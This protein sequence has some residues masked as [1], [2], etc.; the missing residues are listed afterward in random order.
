MFS[1]VKS[2]W[3]R[4][5][6]L[7]R[8]LRIAGYLLSG[9]LV[10]AALLGLALPALLGAMLPGKLSDL[11]GRPVS[12]TQLS[13]NPFTLELEARE[14]ALAESDGS[15]FTGFERLGLN[16]SLWQSIFNGAPTLANL[17]LDGPFGHLLQRADGSF[18]FSSLLPTNDAPPTDTAPA[19]MPA[20]VIDRLR[21]GR[22]Q[23]SVTDQLH[24][25]DLHYPDINF[26][27][28]ALDSRAALADIEHNRFELH[29]A[30]D[31]QGQFSL[32]GHFDLN[33]PGAEVEFQLANQSLLKFWPALEGKL[34]LEPQSARLSLGGKLT[35]ALGT[36]AKPEVEFSKG[37]MVLSDVALKPADGE[38]LSLAS[39]ALDGI[40]M[41]LTR[42]QATAE[43]LAIDGLKLATAFDKQGLG[44]QR[45]WQSQ[46][47]ET[48]EQVGDT[49]AAA[50]TEAQAPQS[51]IEPDAN[52]AWTARLDRFELGNSEL[53]VHEST[54]SDKVVDW[55]I[56]DIQLETGALGSDLTQA[57]TLA[58]SLNLGRN[59]KPEQAA[60]NLN[61]TVHPDSRQAEGQ[62]QLAGLDL[63]QFAPYLEPLVQL[64][65][66][67][68]ILGIAGQFKLNGEGQLRFE[69]NSTL[70]QLAVLDTR[71]KVPLLKWQKL[72]VAGLQI[73]LATNSIEIA[74]LDLFEPYG[75]IIIHEDRTTNISDLLVKAPES[76]GTETTAPKPAKASTEAEPARPM[77]ISIAEINI[78]Q[79]SA[80]FADNSL[81]PHFASGIELLEGKIS[82]LSS[83]P[84]VRSSIDIQ[85]K[86]DRYAPVVLKGEMNPLL[87]KPY[88]DLDLSF[89]NVELTSVNPYSGTYA[90]YY[91]D[92]GQLTLE[93]NY[94]LD[95]NRLVGS[96]HVVVDQLKLGEPSHSDLA[97]SL[98]V[99]LAIALLQDSNGVIDLGLEVKGELDDP[100]F[101]I[102]GI[103]LKAFTNLITKAVTAPF[104]LLAAL[105]G[106]DEELD[107]LA[108]APGMA[109]LGDAQTGKLGALT[110][111]LTARPALKI[112]LEGQVD[113]KLDGPAL[114]EL[115]LRQD[116]Q[117]MAGDAELPEALGANAWPVDG[118]LADALVSRFDNQNNQGA[119][120][121]KADIAAKLATEAEFAN[122]P[123]A[124]SEET[125]K[126]WHIALYNLQHKA[127]PR[128]DDSLGAL[129]QQRAQAVKAAL[130]EQ[131]QL[132][133]ER[134]FLKESRI[135]LAKD[136]ARVTLELGAD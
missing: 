131:F 81:T 6:K 67:Q 113:P 126:R 106:S 41:S 124:L 36:D 74:S 33:Q 63:S 103:V 112:T 29:L 38:P 7:P 4:F 102:G 114:A 39:L 34:L 133:P 49:V 50:A 118:P 52:N 68:G 123:D 48:T 23:F 20:F 96:N 17:E 90:G 62:L 5:I 69:G 116:L 12:L 25:I 127:M 40:R 55:R 1:P 58:A 71:A 75:R 54:R 27:L 97:T 80:F 21:L 83:D 99:T 35:L 65:L 86:V 105:V 78:H 72:D 109:N 87:E 47:P 13:I 77:A 76:Q 11:T 16:F 88:L 3:Q 10:Y 28:M 22:G 44:L 98:P 93:L 26:S 132:A 24:G 115:A 122:A 117:A 73:D 37:R 120:Q 61:A 100:S 128:S 57:V 51:A 46:A 92:R 107:S 56:S 108:F 94:K 45:L 101:S 31:N 42:K 121:L 79:G 82:Q 60:L 19:A 30:D 111:A 18:N 129:A 32:N 64:D 95:N 130:V 119:A 14:F 136:G 9:Y 91:I 110:K 59:D 89:R 85:G 8:S 2:L 84:K 15:P 70:T 43:L 53:L 125:N 134:I 104:S 135:K 66:Q